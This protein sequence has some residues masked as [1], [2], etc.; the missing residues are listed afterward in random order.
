MFAVKGIRRISPTRRPQKDAKQPKD[1]KDAKQDQK[2][3]AKDAKQDRKDVRQD[4]KDAKPNRNV[5]KKMKGNA[6]TSKSVLE[7]Q[8][9]SMLEVH[10]LSR[11][12]L[13][14]QK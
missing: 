14:N 1:R 4:Q 5:A 6:I 7:F 3:A 13:R 12:M 10:G 11:E 8:F 2:D 9:Y